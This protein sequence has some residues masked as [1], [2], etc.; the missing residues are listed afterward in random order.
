MLSARCNKATQQRAS[1]SR[2]LLAANARDHTA[3]SLMSEVHADA[4]ISAMPSAG[5]ARG[6]CRAADV[7]Y[8]NA[9]WTLQVAGR[10]Q[11][12]AMSLGC[13]CGVPRHA[14]AFRSGSPIGH[15]FMLRTRA[16]MPLTGCATQTFDPPMACFS[17]RLRIF[18][19]YSPLFLAGRE[20]HVATIPSSRNS[21]THIRRHLLGRSLACTKGSRP[22]TTSP[23]GLGPLRLSF[24]THF[25]HV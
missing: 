8:K 19:P 12:T 5:D 13:A 21:F 14:G 20:G 7:C 10:C 18:C 24:P 4:T 23:P 16:S 1:I 17:H 11:L 6:Q 25:R 15:G 9:F 2:T 3:L 22:R